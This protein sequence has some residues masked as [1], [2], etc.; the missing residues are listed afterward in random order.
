[1]LRAPG[2]QG[3]GGGGIQ[4]RPQLTSQATWSGSV[5]SPWGQSQ[6]QKEAAGVLQGPTGSSRGEQEIPRGTQSLSGPARP[7]PQQGWAGTWTL[8][9]REAPHRGRGL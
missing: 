5:P 6:L 9:P 4:P 2:A 8:E 3:K 1:M 7:L